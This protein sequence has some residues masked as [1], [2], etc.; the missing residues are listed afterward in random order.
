[1][2]DLTNLN[3]NNFELTLEE[4]KNINGAGAGLINPA[5]VP[6]G[7]VAGTLAGTFAGTRIARGQGGG[8]A[9]QNTAIAFWG[10]AGGALGGASV[11]E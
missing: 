1:M 4:Q 7:R 2:L 3:S 9:S 8:D 11:A 6:A 10:L 5:L